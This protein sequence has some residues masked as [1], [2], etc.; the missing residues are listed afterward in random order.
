MDYPVAMQMNEVQLHT[1]AWV[2]LANNIK[3]EKQDISDYTMQCDPMHM[4]SKA[5]K[6]KWQSL[7]CKY[8]WDAIKNS[9]EMIT[10]KVKSPKFRND[11]S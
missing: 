9:K 11:Y 1:A 8:R 3:R 4:K 10:T 6:T 7:G 5:G 2:N